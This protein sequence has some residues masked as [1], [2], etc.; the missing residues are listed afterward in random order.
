ML[1]CKGLKVSRKHLTL[2]A[3]DIANLP[4]D[5]YLQEVNHTRGSIES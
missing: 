4:L 3:S 2:P 5:S 1:G